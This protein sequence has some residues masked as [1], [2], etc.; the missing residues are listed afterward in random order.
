MHV[1]SLGHRTCQFELLVSS[2]F[3]HFS[4]QISITQESFHVI[5][6][7]LKN[8]V[9]QATEKYAKKIVDIQLKGQF[10]QDINATS[11]V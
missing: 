2:H 5:H 3:F 6:T 1:N 11:Y 8:D 4:F 9:T 7:Q 10:M